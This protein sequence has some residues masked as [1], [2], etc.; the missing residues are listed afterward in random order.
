MKKNLWMAVTAD[1]YE[2]PIAVCDTCR[3]L[4]KATGTDYA[5]LSRRCG[6]VYPKLGIKVLRVE[7][8]EDEG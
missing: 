1:K 8:E 6:S 4:A 5:Y 2:L 3:A 7:V